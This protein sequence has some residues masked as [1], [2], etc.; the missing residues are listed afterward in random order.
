M[1]YKNGGQSM[2]SLKRSFICTLT[3]A[4]VALSSGAL[5][6]SASAEWHKNDDGYYYTLED[7]DRVT[8]WQKIGSYKYYFGSDGIAVTGFKKI[9][10]N[11]Y[12]FNPEKRGRMTTGWKT[13]GGYR[14]FFGNDGVMR[15]GWKTINGNTYYFSSSGKA[16]TGTV[17]I[18]GKT[19]TFSSKGVLQ[20]DTKSS[21]SSASGSS[22][23]FANNAFGKA[24]YGMT[25]EEVIKANKLKNYVTLGESDDY[26]AIGAVIPSY[27]GSPSDETI[28]AFIFDRSDKLIA[29]M[30][31]DNSGSSETAWKKYAKGKYGNTA[32]EE[33]GTFLYGDER[34]ENVIFV[35]SIKGATILMELHSEDIETVDEAFASITSSVEQ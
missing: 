18:G 19:Y 15:T 7:G 13:I 34:L 31:I 14:Y 26:R 8:G 23:S 9:K 6:F 21:A 4:A 5:A 30:A 29:V 28:V 12:Y 3:A 27:L 10:G 2:K 24:D 11:T 33:N 1:N 17:K 22:S 20:T 32:A 16:A 25:S 35:G